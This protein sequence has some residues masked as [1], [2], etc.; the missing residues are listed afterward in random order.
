MSENESSKIAK[1]HYVGSLNDGTVFDSSRDRD[2]FEFAIGTGEVIKGFD[3]A[4]VAMAI[5]E[6]RTINVPAEEAYGPYQ[7]ELVHSVDHSQF[8]E[9]LIPE[10]GMQLESEGGEGHPPMVVTVTEVSDEKVTL[11]ANHPL[12]GKDLTFEVELLEL[13]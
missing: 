9:G 10:V 2:P 11:D 5:G 7:E 4:V 12:A 13:S 6:T 3:D 8:S 1:V